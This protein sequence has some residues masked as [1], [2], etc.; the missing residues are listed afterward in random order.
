MISFVSLLYY[1]YLILGLVNKRHG[2]LENLRDL[3]ADE[4]KLSLGLMAA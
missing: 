3:L 4:T 1:K 2:A